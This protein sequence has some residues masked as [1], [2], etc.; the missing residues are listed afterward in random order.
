M[1]HELGA[2]ASED[3]HH[4]RRNIAHREC[5]GERDG[6]ERRP[7]ARNENGNVAT[8]QYASEARDQPKER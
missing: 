3:V 1:W 4:A 7:L 8:R 5:L 6:G 2:S